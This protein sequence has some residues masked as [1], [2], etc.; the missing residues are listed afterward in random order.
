MDLIDFQ[1]LDT[2]YILYLPVINVQSYQTNTFICKGRKHNKN[3]RETNL[4]KK[5]RSH[6]A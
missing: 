2:N 3:I 5:I 6:F 1:V 4:G